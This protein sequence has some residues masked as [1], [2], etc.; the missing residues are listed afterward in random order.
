MRI[1]ISLNSAMINLKILIASP[2]TFKESRCYILYFES[3]PCNTSTN[4]IIDN[5]STRYNNIKE[6]F[7]AVTYH[8]C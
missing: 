5:P 6:E 8:L 1:N 2:Q 4:L 3:L 7:L